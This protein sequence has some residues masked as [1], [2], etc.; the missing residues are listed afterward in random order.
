L[1]AGLVMGGIWLMQ[2][3]SPLQHALRLLAVMAIVMTTSA[4]VHAWADRTGRHL[5]RHPVGRFL[6]GKLVL[7][8]VAL[9]AATGLHGVL[10]HVDAVV[11]GGMAVAVAALGPMLHPWFMKQR[12][13]HG[14]VAAR[15]SE[16]TSR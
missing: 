15:T 6:L 9:A 4:L 1:F 7:V 12:S 14:A 3:G 11:A 16:G 8:A 2:H 10:P 5:P 13:D